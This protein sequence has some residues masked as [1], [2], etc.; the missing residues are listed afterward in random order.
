M[1]D[2]DST[3]RTP[4]YHEKLRVVF[5][6]FSHSTENKNNIILDFGVSIHANKEKSSSV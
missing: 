1:I 5:L 6:A 3:G 2:G 4:H